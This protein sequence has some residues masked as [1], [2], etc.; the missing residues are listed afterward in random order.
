[1]SAAAAAALQ[2]FEGLVGVRRQSVALAT[3]GQ[4][5]E[6][7]TNHFAMSS[8]KGVF[9]HYDAISADKVLPVKRNLELIDELQKRNAEIFHPRGIYDGKKNMFMTADIGESRTFQLSFSTKPGAKATTIVLKKAQE[10]DPSCLDGYLKGRSDV[11]EAQHNRVLTCIMAFNVAVR[12]VP[13]HKWPFNARS[14][15]TNK[16]TKSIKGGLEIWRGYFQSVRP[17][18]GRLLVN[19]DITAGLMYKPGPLI[20]L[21][22]DFLQ[23]R[24]NRAL[25]AG[26]ISDRARSSL[27]RFIKRIRV[28]ATHRGDKA[29]AASIAEVLPMS[30]A[31]YTFSKDGRVISVANYI[32]ET[33]RLS[34][35][36]PDMVCVKFPKGDVLPLELLTVLPGQLVKN[37]KAQPD[38]VTEMLNF[39]KKR[40][41][42]RINTITRGF[43]MMEYGNADYLRQSQVTIEPRPISIKGRVLPVPTLTF[44]GGIKVVPSGGKWDVMRKRLYEAKR[45]GAWSILVLEAP[46]RCSEASAS[47]FGWKLSQAMKKLEFLYDK[48]PVLTGSGQSVRQSLKA[49]YDKAVEVSNGQVKAPTLVIVIVP[50]PATEMKEEIK[51]LGDI[52]VGFPTQCVRADK[53]FKCNDQYLNNLA[54]KINTKIGGI[55]SV[56]D[57][58]EPVPTMIVGADVSHP[59]PGQETIPSIS[60]LV[61]SVDPHNSVYIA[62][63]EVQESRQEIIADLTTM[64][65]TAIREFNGF[66][67]HKLDGLVKAGQIKSYGEKDVWPHRILFYRDGV[68]EGQFAE[69]SREEVS[70]INLALTEMGL[71]GGKRPQLTF[72]IVGKRHHVR[73]FPAGGRGDR[74]GNAPAGLVV[75]SDITNPIMFDFYLQSHSGLLGTSRPSHYSVLHDENRFNADSLEKISYD[76]CHLY[77]RATR[78]VSIPAPIVCARSRYHFDANMNVSDNATTVSGDGAPRYSLEDFKQGY[79]PIHGSLSRRMYFM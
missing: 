55:N 65:T 67:R 77:A 19:I 75:D 4:P 40:P 64:M 53:I 11:D 58:R 59:G 20:D 76:L 71:I 52:A 37:Y 7:T 23:L 21:C 56:L 38:Q 46:N 25:M 15:F 10:I 39:S 31:N 68:S 13:I 63:T 50:F 57:I 79:K 26:T 48:P 42:E 16:E 35:K 60:A 3:M 62:Q 78:S 14:F 41:D 45:I 54:L 73:F 24:D 28:L 72:I 12:M 74:S 8:P 34:L 70:A 44:G 36:F 69:V 51:R 18:F 29:R 49:A 47:E 66:R 30:A 61:S 17:T 9:Y 6:V 43:E 27:Q 22:M 32:K 1:M 5:I 2:H 33:Y